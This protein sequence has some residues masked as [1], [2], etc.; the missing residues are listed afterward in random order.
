VGRL[1]SAARV[2]YRVLANRGDAVECPICG[3]G[4]KA[5]RDDWNRPNAICWR[6]GSHERHR[7]LWLYLDRLHSELLGNAGDLLHFAP[8]WCLE[9]R[10]RQVPGLRYTTA[11][12]DPTVG[13]LQLDITDMNLPD[14]SFDAIL[15]SHVLEHV[16]DDAAAMRE[17]RRILKPDGWAIVM[18]PLDVGRAHTYEDPSI[19]D[20]ADRER[21]FLQFDHVRL[22]APDIADRL[23]SAG[24]KVKTE[25]VAERLGAEAA[26]RHRLLD[27]D[28]LFLCRTPVPSEVV[29]SS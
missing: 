20:P 12:L 16:E 29:G 2:R 8:E 24:L 3:H 13:E 7:A 1:T 17:L 28:Y 6:C 15:C 22:Y 23:K 14:G 5:F 11:D 27:S 9:H 25:R 26:A 10:L 19:T 18:V 4:F 21:E